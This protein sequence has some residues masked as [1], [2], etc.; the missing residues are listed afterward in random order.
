MAPLSDQLAPSAARSRVGATRADVLA[1]SARGVDKSFVL[2]HAG[3]AHTLR[4][5]VLRPRRRQPP[6]VLRALRELSFD[7]SPGEFVAIVGRNGSGKSTL[8]RCIAGIY[9]VDG[10]Q[11]EVNGRVAPFIELGVGF[12]P[13]L[14][15]S[16]NL[17]TSG[18]M[19][20]ASAREMRR[21]QSEILRFAEL[22]DFAGLKL[23]NYSSGMTL[24]L[25]FALTTQIDADVLL[26]D[27]VF[28]VGDV[29]F[30]ERCFQRFVE[31]KASGRT[32][33]LVTHDMASVRRLCDRALLLH[34]GE[35]VLDGDPE[36]VAVAYEE[37]NARPNEGPAVVHGT[38]ARPPAPP[39]RKPVLGKWRRLWAV[40]F[41]L[42]MIEFKLKYLDAKLGYFWSITRPLLVF[43]LLYVVFTN[44]AHFDNRVNHYALYL[45]TALVLWGFFLDATTSGVLCL[46]R[47]A[48]LLRKLPIPRSAV[49]LGVVLRAL[50][51]LG[52][53]L[54]A[55]VALS[56]LVGA[57]PRL[58]WLELPLLIGMLAVLTTGVTLLAA[59]LYVR[60]RDID[61]IWTVLGQM[62]F[63]GSPI[64][65]TVSFLP[66]SV[67]AD[68][69]RFDP[70]ATIFTQM[71]HAVVDPSAL[72]A[73]S[74]AGGSGW[75]VVS[76]GIC[77]ALLLLGGAVFARVA[78]RAAERL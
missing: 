45:L 58:S 48:D 27:E 51:D 73:A 41:R 46:V 67:R 17:V 35:L 74:V 25:A 63:Y 54:V 69:V 37:L 13:G 23:R 11:V 42:A 49:P 38:P 33:V 24:R 14:S 6:A 72:S 65:Y 30:Q 43:G 40:A 1:V 3:R 70:L 29:G 56:V 57:P 50:L 39:R 34:H 22:E 60:F 78:P 18:V 77:F 32:L 76:C 59:A 52:M 8:L 68:V 21:R 47:N 55:V 16:D 9:P 75:L 12:Q 2:P 26:F 44:V 10:G 71:G 5:Q 66:S 19:M 4:E 64:L 53:N 31:L 62:L 15:A 61:Q 28:A 7:I 36:A 20:G